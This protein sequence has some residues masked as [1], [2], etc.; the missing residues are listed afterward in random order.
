MILK[1]QINTRDLTRP[2]PHLI[3]YCG[4]NYYIYVPLSSHWVEAL[5]V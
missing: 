4:L 1:S 3:K 2:H 5:Q